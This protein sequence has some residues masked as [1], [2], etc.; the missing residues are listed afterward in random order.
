[1]SVAMDNEDDASQ[2]K[3]CLLL[4]EDCDELITQN[5]KQASGQALSRLLNLTDGLLAQ[6]RNVL[7]GL[8]TNEPVGKLHPAMIRPG[9]CLAQIEVGALTYPEATG[10]LGGTAGVRSGG[11]TLAELYA[12]KTGDQSLVL[13]QAEPAPGCY[14]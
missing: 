9:R 10:W 1:M 4:I 13:V 5:A 14:L 12:L 6:G 3:W 8:T 7:I 11:M 2:R